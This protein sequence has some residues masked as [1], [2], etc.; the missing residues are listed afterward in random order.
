MKRIDKAIKKIS[1]T[2]KEEYF[3]EFDHDN[4]NA[5]KLITNV[6]IK[7]NNNYE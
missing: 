2:K 7:M 3:G 1:E 4:I 6:S 5:L